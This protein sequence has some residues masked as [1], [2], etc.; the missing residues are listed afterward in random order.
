[1]KIIN[2]MISHAPSYVFGKF[3]HGHHHCT[4]NHV[5]TYTYLQG[6]V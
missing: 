3:T 4:Q 5:V 1:M 6:N 2:K